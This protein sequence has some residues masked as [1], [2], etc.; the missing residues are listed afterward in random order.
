VIKL[1]EKYLLVTHRAMAV[2]SWG[3]GFVKKMVLLQKI[4]LRSNNLVSQQRT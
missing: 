2:K 1:Y 3:F 4:I